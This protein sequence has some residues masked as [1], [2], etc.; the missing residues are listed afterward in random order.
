MKFRE[1]IETN[2][3]FTVEDI[4]SVTSTA[5]ARTL[6]HRALKSGDIERARRGVYISKVGKYRGEVPDP[7]H[8][9]TVADPAAV[10][11]WHSALVAH[12]VAH[13]VSFVCSFRSSTVRSPFEYGGVRYVPFV[14]SDQPL[15]QVVRAKA[16]GKA[17]VTT[18][19]QTIT[20]CL[21]HPGRAGGIEEA[22]RSCSAFPYVDVDA[23]LGILEGLPVAVVA[24]VGWLLE[25]KKDS[26]GVEDGVL[27]VLESR[28]GRGPSRLDPHAKKSHGWNARWKLY[29]PEKESEVASWI[30]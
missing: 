22:V 13:N 5:T 30:S 19:E 28:L 2:Q 23:L 3:V 15:T 20:D 18:R 21:T 11:S 7:F 26:W 6:L 29:L 25:A 16:Y 24:R 17:T 12:G 4:Y 14:T 8:V 1:Y 10:I 9:V 27:D